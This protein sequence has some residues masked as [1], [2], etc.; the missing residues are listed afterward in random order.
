MK[1]IVYCSK[2]GSV[3]QYAEWLNEELGGHLP[4]IP[5]E[6]IKNKIKEDDEVVFLAWILNAKIQGLSKIDGK[7][8]LIAVFTAGMNPNGTMVEE[9]KSG[10]YIKD[11]V[12]LFTM[13][14]RYD[15]EKNT[16]FLKFI[17]KWVRKSFSKEIEAI[18]EAERSDVDNS[19]YEML[20][21]G[22]D[23]LQRENLSQGVRWLKANWPL[24]N[25]TAFDV[26]QIV[27]TATA[28]EIELAKQTT[29]SNAF[30]EAESTDE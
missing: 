28:E 9:L 1:A 14:G 27:E 26:T 4:V 25:D 21:F 30:N 13:K 7:C 10:N 5:V 15:P 6:E 29:V 19:M 8:K 23:Y 24:D 16:G 11:E 22:G 3:K 20:N 17:M 12:P 18:P 2:H